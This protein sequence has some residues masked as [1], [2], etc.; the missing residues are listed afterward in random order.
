MATLK[1]V[2]SLANVDIS[3]VSRALNGK[4]YVHPETKKRIF[5]AVEKL[6]YHPNVLAKGLR[7]GK[8]HTIAFVVPRIANS[9]YV[10]MIPAISE[11]AAKHGYQVMICTT[12]YDDEKSE[13][14]VLERLRS[15]LVDGIIISSTG[16]NN[17]L[18]RDINAEGIS[19]LQAVRKQDEKLSSIVAD[20]Y[21]TGYEGTKY[22]YSKGCRNIALIIGNLKLHPYMER[23]NG[24]LKA[25]KELSLESRVITDDA[26]P[27][28]FEYGM[29]CAEKI[30]EKYPDTDGIMASLDIQGLGAQRA[31][32]ICGKKCPEE[33]R[34]MSLTGI[35][36][37]SY[38][39][40]TMTSM[41]V[42]AF[43][44]GVESVNML[45]R[46]IESEQSHRSLKNLN[47]KAVL[48]ERETT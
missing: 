40:T 32:K 43:E 22:L 23:Y 31:L 24:Y 7:K 13:K 6:S 15:G 17:R 4:S 46:E 44:I 21:A 30:I 19:V 25:V 20:Y 47:F 28:S 27:N 12:G 14:E 38:L 36:L 18:L 29:I 9:I 5:D 3:T 35:S 48:T 42:P 2:A 8:R 11:T 45:I 37:G 1:D 10:D 39:E 33:V 16:L 41:E 26:E 34:L